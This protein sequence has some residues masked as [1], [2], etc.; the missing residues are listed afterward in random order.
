M[1]DPAH[2]P[3]SVRAQASGEVIRIPTIMIAWQRVEDAI[4]DCQRNG[5]TPD[6]MAT[7]NRAMTL[8][9]AAESWGRR[10]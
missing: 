8:Y 2:N 1:P 10:Y 9:D 4:R 3:D 7:L 6:R 5:R